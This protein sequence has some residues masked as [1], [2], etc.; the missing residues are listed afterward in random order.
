MALKSR[1]NIASK[2]ASKDGSSEPTNFLAIETIDN[3][4]AW[5]TTLSHPV[6]L[7][8]I[9][10]WDFKYMIAHPIAAM[11]SK[12]PIVLAVQMLWCIVC[13]PPA[14]SVTKKGSKSVMGQVKPAKDKD[15]QH[16]SLKNKIVVS[17]ASTRENQ[18]DDPAADGAHPDGDTTRDPDP[19]GTSHPSR[20]PFHVAPYRDVPGFDA[21]RATCRISTHRRLRDIFRQVAG[22]R[23]TI[24][25]DRRSVWR[26]CRSPAGSMAWSYTDTFG[27]GQ[28]VAKIS[29]DCADRRIHRSSCGE[30]AGQVH[31]QG[32]QDIFRRKVDSLGT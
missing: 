30:A 10:F 21:L 22:S 24:L 7:L 6:L 2:A 13:L 12:L 4:I 26:L 18:A 23:W 14:G 32:S 31:V 29:D 5:L 8:S 27:L 9:Y 16:K 25:Y 15:L 11:T 20:R 19:Y 17:E 1:G 3:E 28:G